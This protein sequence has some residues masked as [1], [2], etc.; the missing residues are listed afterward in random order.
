MK[1][2]FAISFYLLKT[3]F[4]NG[5][6]LGLFA[7]LSLVACFIFFFAS[8][9]GEIVNELRIRIRFALLFSYSLLSISLIY[10]ACVSLTKDIEL[11]YF[12]N[13]SSAPVHRAQIWLGKFFGISGLG[14]L[15]FLVVSFFVS[16]CV[17]AYMK[18]HKVNHL[19]PEGSESLLRFYTVCLPD[20]EK[21]DE[22]VEKRYRKLE[23]EG[24]LSPGHDEYEIRKKLREEIRRELQA[25]EPGATKK[26][27]FKWNHSVASRYANFAI[28]KLK[29]YAENKRQKVA[30]TLELASEKSSVKWKK[31]FEAY[32]YG[33]VKFK[34]PLNEI[35]DSTSIELSFKGKNA[36]YL[37]FPSN[38]VSL[39]Y[40]GGG[41]L[42]NYLSML[43]ML[44][45]NI[46][47]ITALS[48]ACS[49]MFTYHVAIFVSMIIY[50]LGS[51]SDFFSS[52]LRDITYGLHGSGHSNVYMFSFFINIGLWLTR[53]IAP[54][55]V[56]ENFTENISINFVDSMP[57]WGLAMI[58]YTICSSLVGIFI[59]TRKEIDKIQF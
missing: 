50:L 6:A 19:S 58:A 35:P 10:I 25:C 26:W 20:E 3:L 24:L 48:L 13:V 33:F 21:L 36:P 4:R 27:R 1:K 49:S 53:G 8:S 55:P 51:S 57:A 42:S 59:L 9:D 54:P 41:L 56:I 44:M 39:L 30:G 12:H 45:L 15:S 5:T 52:V 40:D 23:A 34:I 14:V 46:F 32:P 47:T 2:I 16:L 11:R 7:F 43:V 28:L 38:G 18:I 37:I 31:D 29:F 22:K 17:I